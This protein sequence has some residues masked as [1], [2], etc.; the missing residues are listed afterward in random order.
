MRGSQPK[1]FELHALLRSTLN[2]QRLMKCGG[3]DDALAR[4]PRDVLTGVQP[5]QLKYIGNITVHT[6]C[7]SL[8]DSLFSVV[9][10]NA[11]C[12]QPRGGVCF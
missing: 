2:A 3:L 1:T 8:H 4:R 6:V 9:I 7:A 12:P 5:V 11:P 10:F